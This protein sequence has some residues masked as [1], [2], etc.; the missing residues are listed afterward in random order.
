MSSLALD[1]RTF[2]RVTALASAVTHVRSGRKL[3]FGKLAARAASVP[4]PDL[5]TVT[6]EEPKDFTL[7]GRPQRGVDTP[8][9]ATGKPL[10]G[11]DV[12]VPGMLYAVFEK[13]PVF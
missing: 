11:I 5:K 6:L 9:I 1:R 3:G 10:F 7:I 4:P 12:K 13:C 8:A 2:L